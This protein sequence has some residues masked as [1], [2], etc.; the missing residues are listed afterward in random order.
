[1][2]SKFSSFGICLCIAIND[3]QKVLNMVLFNIESNHKI[4]IKLAN[5]HFFFFLQQLRTACTSLTV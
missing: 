5:N 4:Q 3:R 1:M 2:S